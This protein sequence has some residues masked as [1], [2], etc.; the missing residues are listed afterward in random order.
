[1][2][3]AFDVN[4]NEK[5]RSKHIIFFFFLISNLNLFLYEHRKIRVS[6]S[7][8]KEMQHLSLVTFKKKSLIELLGKLDKNA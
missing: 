5:R 8:L 6:F 7:S 4:C 1:M 2:V 3:V